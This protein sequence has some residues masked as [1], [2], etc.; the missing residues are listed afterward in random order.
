MCVIG[1][2]GVCVYDFLSMCLMN[3]LLINLRYVLLASSHLKILPTFTPPVTRHKT[4]ISEEV[5]TKDSSK[6]VALAIPPT[7]T[8]P[9][10]IS[11]TNQESV[12]S[13]AGISQNDSSKSRDDTIDTSVAM[14]ASVSHPTSDIES[15]SEGTGAPG[16]ETL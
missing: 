5:S 13:A 15:L 7:S 6:V 4:T 10:N 14:E 3:I 1:G 16:S 12:T 8:P 11:S 2:V 9:V